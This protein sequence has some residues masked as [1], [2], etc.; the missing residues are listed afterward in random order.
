M[1]D[2]ENWQA[3]STGAAEME[4]RRQEKGHSRGN[5]MLAGSISLYLLQHVL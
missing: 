2:D 1:K 5:Q 4:D 3:G